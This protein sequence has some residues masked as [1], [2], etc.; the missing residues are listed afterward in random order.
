MAIAFLFGRIIVAVFFLKSA[1]G[2]FKNLEGMSGYAGAKGV[3]APQAAVAGTGAL[4]LLGG[5][6]LLL[7]VYPVIGIGLLVIFLLGVS[8]SMH[9]YWKIA[10]P[11]QRVGEQVNFEKNIALLGSLLMFLSI[12]AP[13]PL[14]LGIGF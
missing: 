14:S 4:L 8:F 10:D 9:A 6:S 12:P 3:P 1:Y 11:Q 5:L 13:W 7:G 2:H